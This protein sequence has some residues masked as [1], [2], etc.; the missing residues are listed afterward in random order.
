MSHLQ[1][2][3]ITLYNYEDLDS[4]YQDMETEFGSD[5]IPNRK[6]EALS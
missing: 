4:F 1:E 2:F 5:I 6:V 3:I